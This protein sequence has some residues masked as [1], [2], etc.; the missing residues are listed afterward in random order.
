MPGTCTTRVR[1]YTSW[2]HQLQRTSLRLETFRDQRPCGRVSHC[3]RPQFEQPSRNEKGKARQ[4]RANSRL[5][6]M[7]CEA[8]LSFSEADACIRPTM[9]AHNSK[10]KTSYQSRPTSEQC[11]RIWPLPGEN[12]WAAKQRSKSNATDSMYTAVN[13]YR[14]AQ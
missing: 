3:R 12:S 10:R 13:R 6:M 7:Q 8:R 2:R 1:L 5:C 14:P 4:E 9:M 11:R